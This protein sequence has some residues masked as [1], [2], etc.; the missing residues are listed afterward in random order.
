MRLW[1]TLIFLAALTLAG[2]GEDDAEIPMAAALD[3]DATGH[4]CNMTVIDH[5]GP[6][7]QIHVKGTAAPVWFSSVRDAVVFT[8]LPEEPKTIVAIYVHDMGRV[9]N[10]SIP[11]DDAW[12]E[13][14]G[15]H[16]V[17]GSKRTGGMGL[18][19]TVP[20]KDME[21]AM[22][23]A[24][25]QGGHVVGWKDIPHDYVMQAPE[26]DNMTAPKADH[27]GHNMNKQQSSNHQTSNHITAAPKHD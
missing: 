26:S 13:A 19:E 2:C 25:E 7:A 20:F 11:S 1:H 18:P 27:S 12:I 15:A 10:W 22:A 5:P 8:L 6:K 9:A 23:F 4:Y 24:G 21:Q 14:R 3:R 16:Y 17:I